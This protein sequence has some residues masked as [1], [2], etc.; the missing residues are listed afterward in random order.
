MYTI[1]EVADELK[2]S[3]MKVWRMVRAGEIKSVRFGTAYR[4][5]DEEVERIKTPVQVDHATTT[6]PSLQD[7]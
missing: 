3:R 7:R 5:P 2:L 1:Q 4:I 6:L